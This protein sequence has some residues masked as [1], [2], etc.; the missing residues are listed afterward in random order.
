M[1]GL[2]TSETAMIMAVLK[3]D[4]ENSERFEFWHEQE[5]DENG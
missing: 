2:K 5:V 3:A 1:A 4:T